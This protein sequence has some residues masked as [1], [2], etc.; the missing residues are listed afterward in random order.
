MVLIK[1]DEGVKFRN[2]FLDI[3]CVP[4]RLVRAREI[5]PGEVMVMDS[6]ASNRQQ[7][8]CAGV[9]A[10]IPNRRRSAFQ[11]GKTEDSPPPRDYVVPGQAF[12]QLMRQNF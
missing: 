8:Q 5:A 12:S 6:F 4:K 3:H 9:Q 10:N 2:R 1:L 11:N 7:L